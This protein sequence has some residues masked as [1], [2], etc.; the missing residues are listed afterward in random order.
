VVPCDCAEKHRTKRIVLTGGPGAGK[1]AALELIRR[2][3]CVHVTVLPEAAGIVFG[4]GFPRDPFPSHVRAAQRAIYYVERELEATADDARTALVLCDRGTVDGAAYWPEPVDEFWG[5]VGTTLEQEYKRYD[6]VIH[7]RTP[8]D[9]DGYNH[10]NPLRIESA[11]EAHRIDDR[12]YH[13]WEGHPRR[14]VVNS[15]PDFLSKAVAVMNILHNELPRC[16][17]QSVRIGDGT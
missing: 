6:L 17:Q 2:T 7:L 13:A 9:G 14:M 15:S 1:T 8:S 5:A 11:A 3:F 4:G 16:C 12:I 10:A